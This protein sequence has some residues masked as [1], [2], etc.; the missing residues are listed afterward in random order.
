MAAARAKIF[1]F[2]CIDPRFRRALEKFIEEK[3]NLGPTE[4]DIKTDAG[5]VNELCK[6]GILSDWMLKNAELAYNQHGT[7]LFVLCNHMGCS[8]YRLQHGE[9]TEGTETELHKIDLVHAAKILMAR[10]PGIAVMSYV[11]HKEERPS[12]KFVFERV[13]IT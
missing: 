12:E 2:A 6:P 5:G 4:Y 1:A 3:F 8:Y 11:V 7:R 10:L 13:P 9:L